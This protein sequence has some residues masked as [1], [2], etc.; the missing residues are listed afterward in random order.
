MHRWRTATTY[1]SWWFWSCKG[2]C[3]LQ[4]YLSIGCGTEYF[5]APEVYKGCYTK[6]A[7]IFSIGMIFCCIVPR[8]C[9]SKFDDKKY[10]CKK[11]LT[12][13]YWSVYSWV[14]AVIVICCIWRW[15]N[16]PNFDGF[17]NHKKHTLTTI[18]RT[19]SDYFAISHFKRVVFIITCTGTCNNINCYTWGT[20]CWPSIHGA[21]VSWQHGTYFASNQYVNL[22]I[23]E[24]YF[25]G[26][27][28]TI[29]IPNCTHWHW[30][31]T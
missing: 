20:K 5:M 13:K 31:E 8:V 25:E 9:W 24:F 1:Q 21:S 10:L 26:T 16:E 28:V 18:C 3:W 14:H 23:E 7:D 29:S 12:E 22:H 19:N 15:P 27:A 6:K 30:N 4:Y 11:W 17:S 2:S